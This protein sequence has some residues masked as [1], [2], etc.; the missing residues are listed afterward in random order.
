MPPEEWGAPKQPARGTQIWFPRLTNPG[1][2]DVVTA[3]CFP[4]VFFSQ[5]N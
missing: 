5:K 3:L 4:C 1:G 2:K